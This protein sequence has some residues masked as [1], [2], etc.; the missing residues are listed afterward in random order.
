[1][2][3]SVE[4]VAKPGR[5]L[6]RRGTIGWLAPVPQDTAFRASCRTFG[7]VFVGLK[8]ATAAQSSGSKLP[9]HR[10]GARLGWFVHQPGSNCGGLRI[11]RGDGFSPCSSCP[12][13]PCPLRD[14][15]VILSV[16]FEGS[17][18]FCT[19]SFIPLYGRRLIS[20]ERL[21]QYSPGWRRPA[22]SA[23]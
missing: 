15:L 16:R 10:D 14:L 4:Q 2:S 3:L 8:R 19:G 1:M 6:G 11:Y 17:F 23:E 13:S 7:S 22:P 20:D 5:F 21:R 18:R 9:R 12:S